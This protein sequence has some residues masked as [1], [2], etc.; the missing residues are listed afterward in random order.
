M[1]T[2]PS[3]LPFTPSGTFVARR[4]F[5]FQGRNY[6]VGDPFPWQK[7][8]CSTRKLRILFESK[9]VGYDEET[10]DKLRGSDEGEVA[11]TP[12][13][14]EV[15]EPTQAEDTEEGDDEATETG[16]TSYEGEEQS[17]TIYDPE[18]HQIVNPERGVWQIVDAEG[19]VIAD[20]DRKLARSLEK[21]DAPV[22]LEITED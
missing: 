17:V 6:A 4:Q 21:A 8:S 2:N 20:I 11:N 9:H 22:E 18:A 7:L 10:A 13:P 16:E 19:E 5:R 1:T 12:E 14:T 3:R 15:V